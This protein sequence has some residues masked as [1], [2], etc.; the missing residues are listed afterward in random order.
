VSERLAWE[1]EI[2]AKT[3]HKKKKARRARKRK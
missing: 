2:N 3:K 1:A